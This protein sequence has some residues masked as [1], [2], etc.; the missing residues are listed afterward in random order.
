MLKIQEFGSFEFP[1]NF[2]TKRYFYILF[3]IQNESDG[4]TGFRRK[5]PLNFALHGGLMCFIPV[6]TLLVG[7]RVGSLPLWF[8]LG[9]VRVTLMASSTPLGFN[10]WRTRC[11]TTAWMFEYCATSSYFPNPAGSAACTPGSPLTHLAVP[12][13]LWK[14]KE[15]S[16]V[17]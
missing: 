10:Q 3:F 16:Q 8:T 7:A 12:R 17:R 6:S 5:I 14:T 15:R 9:L 13:G 2:L 4:F 11:T 1:W